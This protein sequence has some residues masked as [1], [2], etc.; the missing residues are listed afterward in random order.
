MPQ[1]SAQPGAATRYLEAAYYLEH[2]GEQV[3]PG[4]LAE[5]LGVSPPTVT[6]ALRRLQRDGMVTSDTSRRVYLTERGRQAAAEIVRRHRVLEV[7]LTD[8]LGLDWV[9]A[10][11]EA[12][13]LAPSLSE[14]VLEGL[15]RSLGDP[16]VCPHG[17]LIPGVVQPTRRLRSLAE[18]PPGQ[19][20]PLARISE[21]AEHDAP[22]V[23]SFL[24]SAG[25][26]PGERVRVLP[27]V[28]EVGV[29]AVR[30]ADGRVEH[31]SVAVARV[32]WVEDPS[33]PREG[34]VT[35]VEGAVPSP[36]V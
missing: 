30:R 35:H 3:R 11:T 22:A 12:H 15:Q 4:R 5:W 14:R 13:R 20:A 29:V 6:E 31:L 24:Y 33:A 27:S 10:D 21:L 23:L 26:V 32:V 34:V 28:E 1:E 36:A 17:N 8:V 2:E 25:L 16:P 19:E 9:E 18:L 7:W